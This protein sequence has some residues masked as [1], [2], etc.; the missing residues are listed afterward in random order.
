MGLDKPIIGIPGWKVGDNSFGVTTPYIEFFE[1]Y[2]QVKVLNL[3][4][5]IDK[6]LDLL[7]IP[8]GVDINPQRYNAIPGFNTSKSDPIKEYFEYTI[9]PLYIKYGTPIFGICRGIQAIAV[10]F[11]AKLVQDMYHETNTTTEGRTKSVHGLIL[12]TGSDFVKE[13]TSINH[14]GK[15]KV[16]SLH[17]QCVSSKMLPDCL[18]IVAI[19]EGKLSSTSPIEALIH[20]TLPIMGVQYH[21]EEMGFEPLSDFMIETLISKS[22]N[23]G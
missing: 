4:P 5:E 8:G 19:Y 16:N 9:M 2:G 14:K 7:V 13:F 20:K 22:K 21:P 3:Y 6:S 11:G 1:Q 12:N 23:N 10:H 15:L 17:H 18:E